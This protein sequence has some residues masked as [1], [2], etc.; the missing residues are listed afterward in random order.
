MSADVVDASGAVEPA[1]SVMLHHIVFA[2]GS[3]DYTCANLPAQRFYAEGEE[4]A[5]MVLPTGFGYPNRA[6]DRWGLLYMLMNHHASSETVQIRYTC[7][8]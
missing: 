4:L 3:P 7:A 1:G 8:P 5:A 6:S 2:K